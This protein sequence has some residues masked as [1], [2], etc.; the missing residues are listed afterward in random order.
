MGRALLNGAAVVA[1]CFVDAL[2][3]L[4][5]SSAAIAPGRSYRVVEPAAARTRA[6][7]NR[8]TDNL[9]AGGA[10]LNIRNAGCSELRLEG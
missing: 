7:R 1:Y 3:D 10:A 9:R 8:Q 2:D 5:A 6:C 4:N